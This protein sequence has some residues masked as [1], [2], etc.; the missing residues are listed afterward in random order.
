MVMLVSVCVGNLEMGRNIVWLVLDFDD[1]FDFYVGVYWDLC[2][3]EGVVGMGID[4][5]IE[6]FVE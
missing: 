2:D 6:D 4:F 5:G 1:C 3:V